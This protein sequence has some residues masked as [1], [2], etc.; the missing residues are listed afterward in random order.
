MKKK[1]TSQLLIF[2]AKKKISRRTSPKTLF[3]LSYII[4]N[5]QYKT[6]TFTQMCEICDRYDVQWPTVMNYLTYGCR[7]HGDVWCTYY[8]NYTYHF[9]RISLPL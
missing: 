4:A 3:A 6:L 7:F 9:K 2:H 8:G 1:K 5:C